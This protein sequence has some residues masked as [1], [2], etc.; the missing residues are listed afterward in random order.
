[1]NNRTLYIT[2]AV[3]TAIIISLIICIGINNKII[4][5]CYPIYREY[6]DFNRQENWK[7]YKEKES[8]KTS[9]KQQN[10]KSFEEYVK[11]HYPDK[12]KEYKESYKRMQNIDLPVHESPLIKYQE[13]NRIYN[14]WKFRTSE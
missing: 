10:T 13:E 11:E 4:D 6:Y 9:Q 2:I 7:K 14:E 1:M 3:L 12:Y 5:E 8:N